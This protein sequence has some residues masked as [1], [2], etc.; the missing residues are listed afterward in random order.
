M[1]TFN[2]AIYFYYYAG[3]WISYSFYRHASVESINQSI[4]QSKHICI[5][6]YVANESEA[7]SNRLVTYHRSPIQGLA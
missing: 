2:I 5:A 1:T 7:E 3:N 4:N 6:P